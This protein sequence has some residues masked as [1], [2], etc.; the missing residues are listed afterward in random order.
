MS[1][2]ESPSFDEHEDSREIKDLQL[3]S[4]LFPPDNLQVRGLLRARGGFLQ[5]R[6]QKHMSS[7][8]PTVAHSLRFKNRGSRSRDFNSRQSTDSLTDSIQDCVART[9]LVK[10]HNLNGLA[11]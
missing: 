1:S 7:P 8:H 3:Q 9:W 10:C 5:D 6:H 11:H 2:L 4:Y